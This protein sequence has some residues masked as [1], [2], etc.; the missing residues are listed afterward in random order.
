MEDGFV[1]EVNNDHRQGNH[2]ILAHT[3]WTYSK[4]H[5]FIMP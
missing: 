5:F 2:L 1:V 4:S 3:L